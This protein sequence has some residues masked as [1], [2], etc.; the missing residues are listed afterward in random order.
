MLLG[1]AR[2]PD[3]MRLY[4]IGDVHGCSRMLTEMH[5]RVA[6]DLA[7][8]PSADHR[9]IHIGDYTDRGPDSAGVVARLA[10]MTAADPRVICLNG[11]HDQYLADFLR[12]PQ[13]VGANYLSGNV[14]GTSTLR[15]YGVPVEKFEWLTGDLASLAGKLAQRMPASHR[16]FIDALRLSARFGDYFFCHAGIRPGVPLERQDPDDLIWMRE[17]FLSDT[18]DHGVVVV[19]GHTPDHAPEV[20][21][22]RINIDTGAVYGGPLTCL[23]LDGADHRFLSVGRG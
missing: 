3:G 4:A 17:P 11:N 7:A 5:G 8:R 22:N 9:I 21:P 18:R 14:G 1:D 10:A 19:H 6:D 13:V 2:T 15:S 16:A 23:V 20:R 12:E